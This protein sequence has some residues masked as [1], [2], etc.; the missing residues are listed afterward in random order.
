[1]NKPDR[2]LNIKVTNQ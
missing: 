1:M 2:T